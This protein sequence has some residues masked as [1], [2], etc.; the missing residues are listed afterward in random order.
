MQPD[1]LNGKAGYAIPIGAI[2]LPSF[3]DETQ[4]IHGQSQVGS[5][6]PRFR[7]VSAL[8]VK[9]THRCNLDCAYC[10]EHITRGGDMHIDTFKSMTDRALSSTSRPS[11][12]FLFHGGE[13][14]L[15][16]N[17]W[18]Q[19]A[20]Q[21]A[22]ARARILRRRATFSIQSNLIALNDSKL[23]L[24]HDLGI[25]LSVSLDGPATVP[26]SLRPRPDAAFQTYLNAKSMGLHPGVLMTINHS[27][28]G[29][30]SEICNWLETDAQ[31][32]SFKANVVA[33]VGRGI[34][35]PSLEPEQIFLAY[36]D[37]LEYMISTRGEAV[38]EDNLS[39][40]LVR[41]FANTEERA[42]LPQELCRE[43]NCGAGR[44]VIG[45]TPEG[46]L[47]PCGRFQWDDAAYYLGH[48]LDA[49]TQ[50]CVVSY[51]S[52]VSQFHALVPS[53]WYDCDSCVARN[54]CS[55]G[56]QAFV[57]R[58]KQQ[59]NLDC[60]PTKM[61]YA[62]FAENRDRLLPVITAIR[63]RSHQVVTA[64]SNYSDAGASGGGAYSDAGSGGTY[65]DRNYEDDKRPY[66]DVYSDTKYSDTYYDKGYSD[67]YD[68]SSL[69]K[70]P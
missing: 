30:F 13:P 14:T 44:Q 10:Y 51:D 48:L 23:Q 69:F 60:L 59:A 12:L 32:R 28:F 11:V 63:N 47:L 68:D 56:C 61:R 50:D 53:T 42:R 6:D 58:S 36:R 38:L 66:Q 21:Y 67:T 15:M 25:E 35:L 19:E 57:V 24:L 39:L 9:V 41:F 20:V 17:A 70:R 43:R 55:H 8:I 46:N 26:H 62:F 52:A 2:T 3:A 16:S 64:R 65:N 31:A 49:P 29:R 4:V 34:N 37:I 7:D 27:N 45:V 22:R 1:S 40:E 54:I 5:P 18:F 33:S